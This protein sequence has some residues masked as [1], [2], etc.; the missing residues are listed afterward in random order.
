MKYRNI[1]IEREYGCGGSEIGEL[2]AKELGIMCCGREL[3]EK[4]AQDLNISVSEVES[5][6]EHLVN[7]FLYSV[8]MLGSIQN[9]KDGML[10]VEQKVHLSMHEE[11]QKMA[12][13]GRCVFIGHCAIDALKDRDDVLKVFIRADGAVKRERIIN[14]YGISPE[15]ADRTREKT[16]KRRRNIFQ[17]YTSKKWENPENYDLI[18]DSGKLGIE[19]CVSILVGLLK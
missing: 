7:S 15:E 16:D 12:R 17:E 14:E 4:T 11:M 5:R 10:S 6:E 2:A 19:N 3:Y 1:A 13:K 9:G 8:A 18:L